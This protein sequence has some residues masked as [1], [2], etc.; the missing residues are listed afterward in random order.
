[1]KIAHQ[2][3]RILTNP[4]NAQKWES[5]VDECRFLTPVGS[6]NQQNS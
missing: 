6:Q 4:N 1:M 3:Q 5:Q 2:S